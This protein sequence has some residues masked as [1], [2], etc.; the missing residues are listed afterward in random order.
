MPAASMQEEEA[1]DPS[2]DE[3]EEAKKAPIGNVQFLFQI[4]QPKTEHPDEDPSNPLNFKAHI[5]GLANDAKDL[6][7]DLDA[8]S[9]AQSKLDPSKRT[10]PPCVVLS[11]V[12]S[13]K[14]AQ[15]N[16]T[17]VVMAAGVFPMAPR[18]K[19]NED[20]LTDEQRAAL[21]AKREAEFLTERQLAYVAMT[22]AAKGLTV[23]C[24]DKS[25]YGRDAG[26]SIFVSEAGLNIGQNVA[27]KN[28]PTPSDENGQPI[29][30]A[31]FSELR[32]EAQPEG[33]PQP[34]TLAYDRRG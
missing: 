4:A 1:D 3:E 7:V 16:N 6:R 19:K 9:V 24:P 10:S 23:V 26:T 28:D 11:T 20:Q 31:S 17:T 14:G 22:R 29:K 34:E 5:D 8:W 15:W 21:A 32:N 12:H 25:V 18:K 13:V 33:P 30:T 2:G 27:G